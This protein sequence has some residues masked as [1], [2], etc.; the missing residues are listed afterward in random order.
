MVAITSVP[1]FPE[2][3]KPWLQQNESI[4]FNLGSNMFFLEC[5]EKV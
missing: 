2:P 5:G 3:Q 4:K 1:F